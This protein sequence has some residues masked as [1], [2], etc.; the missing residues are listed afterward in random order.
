MIVGPCACGAWHEKPL[1]NNMNEQDEGRIDPDFN[2]PVLPSRDYMNL[3]AE[4]AVLISRGADPEE[5]EMPVAPIDTAA[6][7][8]DER[9]YEMG[10]QTP[11]PQPDLIIMDE[12]A[13]IDPEIFEQIKAIALPTMAESLGASIDAEQ[14]AVENDTINPRT[15]P[16]AFALGMTNNPNIPPTAADYEPFAGTAPNTNPDIE[17]MAAG[18]RLLATGRTSVATPNTK[19]TNPKDGVGSLKPSYT[20]VPVPVLYEIGAALTEGARK[21]GGYNWR[22][23]GVRTS[24]YIDATRRHIDDFWEG[25]DIDPDSGLSHITKAIASLVVFRDAQIQNM[26]ANDDRPPSSTPF[27][28]DARARVTDIIARYPNPKP[29]FTQAEV[30]HMRNTPVDVYAGQILGFELEVMLPAPDAPEGFVWMQQGGRRT[31]LDHTLAVA[32]ALRDDGYGQRVIRITRVSD[33]VE[34]MNDGNEYVAGELRV[35]V[36]TIF[37]GDWSLTEAEESEALEYSVQFI[38]ETRDHIITHDATGRVWSGVEEANIDPVVMHGVD[39]IEAWG[40]PDESEPEAVDEAAWRSSEQLD[41]DG[42]VQE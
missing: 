8:G 31:D 19:D 37:P 27:M 26:V 36:E 32:Q 29:N 30:A 42:G 41:E 11:T 13:N 17:A 34:L 21:Y 15:A 33:R 24:V 10:P 23:A 28:E 1:E 40:Q 9:A 5:L 22:V 25:Q 12:A 3:L 7:T 39:P 35:P 16:N 18:E 14:E 4:R 6:L 20:A 2:P 38:A